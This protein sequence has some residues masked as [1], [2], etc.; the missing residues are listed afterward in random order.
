MTGGNLVEIDA[1]AA[2]ALPEDVRAQMRTFAER[3]PQ[4]EEQMNAR[5]FLDTPAA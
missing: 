5:F 1:A 3:F 2:S 4:D